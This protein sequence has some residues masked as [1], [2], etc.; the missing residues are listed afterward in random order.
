MNEQKLKEK[1][2]DLCNVVDEQKIKEEVERF[3]MTHDDMRL[4]VEW[5]KYIPCNWEC[6]YR[7]KM[8]D[9]TEIAN[10]FLYHD[11]K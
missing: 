2:V 1:Y 8:N 7:Y 11:K 4:P 6:Y 3:A 10:V 9:G 5:L